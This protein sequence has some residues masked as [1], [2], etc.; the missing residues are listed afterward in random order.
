MLA[1]AVG[2]DFAPVRP[3]GKFHRQP[4]DVELADRTV[5]TI[6]SDA[7]LM[8]NAAA[9]AVREARG[10]MAQA[11]AKTYCPNTSA[12][13]GDEASRREFRAAV[14]EPKPPSECW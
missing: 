10:Q 9:A 7:R 8:A 13:A 6:L 2:G 14:L 12:A 5:P 11:G 4:G 1:E 3:S